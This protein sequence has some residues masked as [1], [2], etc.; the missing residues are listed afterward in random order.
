M[1]LI[2]LLLAISIMVL[3]QPLNVNPLQVEH[4]YG[5]LRFVVGNLRKPTTKED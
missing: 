5:L 4:V 1:G 2:L 3:I